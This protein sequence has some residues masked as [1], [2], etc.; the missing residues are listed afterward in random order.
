MVNPMR[1]TRGRPPGFKQPHKKAPGRP[2]SINTIRAI[3]VGPG[4]TAARLVFSWDI[5]EQL[6]KL[7]DGKH[8]RLTNYNWHTLYLD[9]L[10][11]NDMT[12]PGVFIR[13][14]P[15]VVLMEPTGLKLTKMPKGYRFTTEAKVETFW[16]KPGFQT[17]RCKMLWLRNPEGL[18]VTFRDEDMKY[19]EHKAA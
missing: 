18:M 6:L 9:V 13:L 5:V 3:A 10:T 14:K 16:L 19:A 17:Q 12:I 2:P 8:Q 7:R 1:L 11:F 15:R 4:G